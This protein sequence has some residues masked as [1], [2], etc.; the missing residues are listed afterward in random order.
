MLY[1]YRT[2][3]NTDKV[4][5]AANQLLYYLTGNPDETVSIYWT[6]A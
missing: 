1:G 3:A 5:L 2:P 6:K 4:V